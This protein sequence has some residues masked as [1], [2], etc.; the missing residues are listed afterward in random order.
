MFVLSLGIVLVA[1]LLGIILWNPKYR[2]R[3]F[4]RSTFGIPDRKQYRGR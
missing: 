1:L 2:M 4:G 3:L